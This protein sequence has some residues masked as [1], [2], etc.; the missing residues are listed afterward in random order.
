MGFGPPSSSLRGGVREG[1]QT[2][3]REPICSARG[4]EMIGFGKPGLDAEVGKAAFVDA[5]ES[6]EVVRSGVLC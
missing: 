1:E 2:F 6:P 5:V 4:G 3:S